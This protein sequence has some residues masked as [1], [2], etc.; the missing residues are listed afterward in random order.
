M[1]LDIK[2]LGIL[3]LIAGL[4]AFF[5]F[6]PAQGLKTIPNNLSVQTLDGENLAFDSLK[7]KPYLLVFWSTSCPGCVKEIPTLQA[8][9]QKWQ[10]QGFRIIAAAMSYDEKTEIQAMKAQKGINY[11]V[12]YDQNGILAKQFDVRVTPTSFLVS[13][14]GK[15]ITQRLGEWK[16]TELEQ[17]ISELLKG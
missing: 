14:E 2:G 6:M 13:A 11:T 5:L 15:I 8:I 17:K 7:G 12:A 1:K 3:A 9:Y 16:H 4:I 10:G